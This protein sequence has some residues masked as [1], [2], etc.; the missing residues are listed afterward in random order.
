[1]AAATEMIDE[2]GDAG[3]LTLRAVARNV[4]V[5]APSVY[6]H[7]SD[8]EHLKMAV[9]E[10]SFAR[11]VKAR[12]EISKGVADPREALLLRCRGYCRFAVSNPGPYRFM[13]SEQS[14]ADGR[15]SVTG[16]QAFQAL[17]DAIHRCQVSGQAS[18][19]DDPASLAAHLW[20]TL[21]GLAMLRLNVPEF[22]WPA[23]IEDMA[24]LAASRLL[25]LDS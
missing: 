17:A 10:R 5:A 9:V 12:D 11:F 16:G 25:G 4:G 7:F 19:K 20:A 6:R 15:R 18:A 8:L 23:P 21:H 13:F 3:K 2:S 24:A 14:P 1:V 22:P